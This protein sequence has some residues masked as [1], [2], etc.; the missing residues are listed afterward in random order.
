MVLLLLVEIKRKKNID[1]LQKAAGREKFLARCICASE[2]VFGYCDQFRGDQN[3]LHK[4]E[5]I[6]MP[7]I[8]ISAG[9]GS[10]LLLH[11]SF[12]ELC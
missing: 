6:F 8:F 4:N 10:I 11:T 5:V 2:P 12:A 1:L 3:M 9:M 7:S